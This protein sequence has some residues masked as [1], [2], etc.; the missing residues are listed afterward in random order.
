[1]P[2]RTIRI[3]VEGAT[4]RLGGTQHLRSL[5]AI[6]GEGGLPLRSGDRLVPEP[7]LLGRSAEKLAGMAAPDG[8]AWS[9]DRDAC[10]ADAS[11]QI[12]FDAAA[13][14]GRV[15]RAQAAIAAGKH[16][17]LEKPTAETFEQALA[18]ARAA[19]R[20]RVKH[21]VVQDKIFLPGPHKL[22]KLRASGF[23]G[24]ILSAQLG[25]GWWIFDG[26]SHPAQRPSWNYKKREGGGLVL[27]MFPHWRYIVDRLIGDI[28]GVSC[29][30]AT[31]IP[32]RRDE[33]GKLYDVDVEDTALAIF[34]LAGGALV[35]VA[36]SWCTRVKRDDMMTL[37]IDGTDGS[38]VCGIHR[39]YL[40]PL[41]ATP[42]PSFNIETP[43]TEDFDAQWQEV[44]DTDGYRNPYRVGWEL[45]LR[46][47]SEG[48]P[49]PYTLLE[50]AKG[51]QLADACYRSN[52]ERRWI[53]LDR[54]T[55]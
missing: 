30:L 2:R 54:L 8:L 1:M 11:T 43:R 51:V 3:V 16:V 27:D 24:K 34:E 35:H 40:Q 10:L 19:E 29:R 6:R 45:F 7:I 17:Y 15:D 9:T 47:V 49:F 42:K 14:A 41:A 22:A 39:C 32:R 53:E 48:A 13:T 23:F 20:A 28:T 4:G 50:G 38:A 36:S 52:A 46:H 18:L 5:L 55:P 44:P 21:G 26:E 12:Y 37:Q 31:Q 25:F 33:A